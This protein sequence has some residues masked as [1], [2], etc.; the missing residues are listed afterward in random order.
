[1]ESGGAGR[2][3]FRHSGQR[4]Y[5]K[6]VEADLKLRKVR[7]E[8]TRTKLALKEK[9]E[10]LVKMES[11]VSR[12]RETIGAEHATGTEE[13]SPE[14]PSN[15]TPL[16]DADIYYE[17][18]LHT[19]QSPISHYSSDDEDVP[20]PD[21]EHNLALKE[22]FKQAQRD[23]EAHLPA[24][25]AQRAATGTLEKKV[26]V[27]VDPP[28]DKDAA[29]AAEAAAEAAAGGAAAAGSS[30]SAARASF[31]VNKDATASQLHT[32][33]V[34]SSSGTPVVTLLE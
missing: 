20:D 1:M 4:D 16:H 28:S 30:A 3:Q 22:R 31:S 5:F 32:V 19:V 12:M 13:E 17:L 14:D 33:N 8:V 15:V 10:E 34:K 9:L 11:H 23:A 24:V 6:T 29:A 26:P 25:E 2:P 7:N 27:V 18:G 21:Q